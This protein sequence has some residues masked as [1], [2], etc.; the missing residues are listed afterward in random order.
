MRLLASL[1]NY[2][3]TCHKSGV[4]IHQYGNMQISTPL[5][6]NNQVILNLETEYPWN[7]QIKITV[8]ESSD[9]PWQLDLRVPQ[10]CQDF[11]IKVNHQDEDTI[12]QKGYAT[13]ERLWKK[14]DVVEVEFVMPPF[15][16]EA[17]PR[18]DNLRSC[19]AVQRGP[20]VYCLEEHDQEAGVN[21][22]DVMI[23]TDTQII[24][25]KQTELLGSVVTLETTGYLSDRSGWQENSLYR[26]M[27]SDNKSRSSERKVKLTA[28]PYYAW[29]NRGLKSMRVWIPRSR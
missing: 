25:R 17:D 28:I 27:V 2:F 10:W 24:S 7:G 4:Q 1:P 14:G 19:V 5:S 8:T 29:G 18:V 6:E 22:L 23:D 3:A 16:V 13:M 20:I 15:L 9:Q 26:P 21:L 11:T 12:L